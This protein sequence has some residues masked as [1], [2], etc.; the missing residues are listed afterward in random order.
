MGQRSSEEPIIGFLKETGAGMSI[1]YLRRRLNLSKCQPPPATQ[2]S[3][4]NGV[5][6]Y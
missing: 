4:R 1:R 5:V 3:D 2:R 6:E